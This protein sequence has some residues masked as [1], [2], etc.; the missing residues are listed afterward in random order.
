MWA[1]SFEEK[2]DILDRDKTIDNVQIHNICTNVP[3]SQIIIYEKLFVMGLKEGLMNEAEK[4]KE[5]SQSS[6]CPVR[7]ANHIPPEHK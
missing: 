3:S 7:E 2:Q 4:S 1:D 6:E 5:K